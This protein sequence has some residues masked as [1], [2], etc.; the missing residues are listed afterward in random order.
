[1]GRTVILEQKP[2]DKPGV[3]GCTAMNTRPLIP[4]IFLGGA[5]A[6]GL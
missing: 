6:A 2:V 3:Y 5:I 1:M 4:G